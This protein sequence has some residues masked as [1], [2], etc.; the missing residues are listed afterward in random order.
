M[1][2]TYKKGTLLVNNNVHRQVVINI[3][4]RVLL[5]LS[6]EDYYRLETAHISNTGHTTEEDSRFTCYAAEVMNLEQVID[7]YKHLKIKYADATHVSMAYRL[8]G[9]NVAELQD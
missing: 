8:P 2:V 5:T 9:E 1:E 7:N 6:D 4:A 3:N